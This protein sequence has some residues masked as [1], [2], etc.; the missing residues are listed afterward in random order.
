MDFALSP[1]IRATQTPPI[2]SVRAWAARYAGGAGP[3]LDLTQATPRLLRPG[4]VT[5]E[6]LAR[7]LEQE[8]AEAEP[9]AAIQAPGM[10]ASHYAPAAPVRLGA[11]R[12]EEDEG[13]LT[14]GPDRF[15]LGGAERL[16]LSP[17]GDLNE[18]AANLFA[19]LRAL[20]KQAGRIAVS[21]IPM[22]GLGEAIN[23]RLCRAAAP[24]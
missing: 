3:V 5:R 22:T 23:D 18:A 12:A 6:E 24:R 21:P 4:S 8:V 1:R 20:D 10:L 19:M 17:T 13:L 15:V 11:V 14:F 9:G 16:N 7:A 2:P